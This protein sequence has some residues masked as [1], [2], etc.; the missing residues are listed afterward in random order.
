MRHACLAC[1]AIS[2]QKRCPKHR[3]KRDRAKQTA[4]AKA[5]KA[6]AGGRCERC[7]RDAADLRRLGRPGPQA[8]HTLPLHEGGG[9][10][11]SNGEWLCGDC[12]RAVDPYAR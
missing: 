4:F 7:G 1:G 3:Y 5:V 2:D 10:A 11:V 12:H 8:H 9:Y 6:R